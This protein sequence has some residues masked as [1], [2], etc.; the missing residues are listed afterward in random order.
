MKK[1][2]RQRVLEYFNVRIELTSYEI[3]EELKMPISH[4]G[5]YLNQYVSEGKIKIIDKTGRW[6]IYTLIPREER[7]KLKNQVSKEIIEYLKFLNDFFKKNYKLLS[8]KKSNIDYVLKNEDKFD[9]I[10]EMVKN[11]N[12]T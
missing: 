2:D 3:S 1:S 10:E 4:V 11:V 9:K 12:T 7:N 6:N 5:Q 8:S